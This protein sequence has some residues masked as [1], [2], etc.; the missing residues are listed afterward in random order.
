MSPPD[1][2]TGPSLAERPL[3]GN[4]AKLEN[5]PINNFYAWP[6]TRSTALL[7]WEL[8]TPDWINLRVERSTDGAAPEVIARL[9]RSEQFTD[10]TVPM[11]S[12]TREV[13]YRIFVEGGDENPI[14]TAFLGDTAVNPI[15][16]AMQLSSSAFAFQ[17][18]R[19]PNNCRTMKIAVVARATV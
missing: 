16:D 5:G 18:I 15:A 10:D 11:A 4:A 9:S 17:G 12:L 19:L 13:V 14:A 8:D 3:T 6:S 2:T 7:T 1:A